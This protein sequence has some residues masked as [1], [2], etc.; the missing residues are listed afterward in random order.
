MARIHL[1]DEVLNILVRSAS[2]PS[3]AS[4]DVTLT[5]G[6]GKA[7][8]GIRWLL[9]PLD[10]SPS[11]G[12]ELGYI[13]FGDQK[14]TF[15]VPPAGISY[16]NSV[17]GLTSSVTISKPISD[18]VSLFGKSGA[19]VWYSDM[20]SSKEGTTTFI[21]NNFTSNSGNWKDTGISF[22][23]GAGVEYDITRRFSLR[24]EMEYFFNVGD[25]DVSMSSDIGLLSISGMYGF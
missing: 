9:G 15:S 4:G 22:T 25:P 20:N 23:A 10:E 5:P 1:E 21:G 12:V 16:N 17:E 6:A 13:R 18:Q 19:L 24:S 11:M 7:F 8:L 2:N 3:S 14:G